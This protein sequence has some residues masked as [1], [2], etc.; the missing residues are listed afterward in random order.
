M[1]TEAYKMCYAMALNAVVHNNPTWSPEQVTNRVDDLATAAAERLNSRV[2]TFEE[3]ERTRWDTQKADQET[4]GAADGTP[5]AT[6]GAADGT[7]DA[8]DPAVETPPVRGRRS[9]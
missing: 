5:D 3:M 7:P 6:D 1:K 9:R 4:S 8:T 2:E